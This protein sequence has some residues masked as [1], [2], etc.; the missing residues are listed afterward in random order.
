MNSV[1]GV[2]STNGDS[3]NQDFLDNVMDFINIK[4]DDAGEKF[5]D[6]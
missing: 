6:T 4:N 3:P 1:P 5:A 2:A